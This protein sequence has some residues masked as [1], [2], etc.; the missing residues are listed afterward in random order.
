MNGINMSKLSHP[1]KL[2]FPTGLLISALL[3]SSISITLKPSS[4]FAATCREIDSV[5]QSADLQ[6][7]TRIGGHVT[8][9]IDG[10]NPPPN[11]SQ[12][13]KT[14]FEDQAKFKN[15]WKSYQSINNPVQCTKSAASQT[16]DIHK[17][18]LQFLGAFS[19]TEADANGHCTKKDSYMAKEVF[20]GFILHD[21][22]WILNT[23]YPIPNTK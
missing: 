17:L 23:A 7:N 18:N 16:V 12:K 20:F 5:K 11:T 10:L 22:K 19:C 8:Q 13:G 9:H 6:Q 1:I 21:G 2:S 4:A 14:L 3:F 15:A